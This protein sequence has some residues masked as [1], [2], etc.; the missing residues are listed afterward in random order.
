MNHTKL[1]LKAFK[2]LRN[3]CHIIINRKENIS[4]TLSLVSSAIYQFFQIELAIGDKVN[5]WTK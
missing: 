2:L 3:F 1:S 4:Y 5:Q